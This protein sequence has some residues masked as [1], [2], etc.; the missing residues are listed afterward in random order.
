M[1]KEHVILLDSETDI[2]GQVADVGAIIVDRSGTVVN[3]FAVL[4]KGVYDDRINHTLFYSDQCG[5]LWNQSS[6]ERRYSQYDM[7]L[8]SGS[9]MLTSVPAINGWLM[10]AKAQYNPILTAYNLPFDV[11]HCQQTG[12]DLTPFTRRFCLWSASVSVFAKT[13]KYRQFIL[14]HHLFKPVTKLGNMSYP[15]N[16]ETMARFILGDISIPDEPHTSLEDCIGY[17]LPVLT[18][19]LRRKFLKWLLNEPVPY[20]WHWL[21]Q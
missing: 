14:D 4:V 1:R 12:I 10:R 16:C 8:K 11:S 2:T 6:L 20:S 15:T 9:R 5:E 13:K 7:M 18:K 17:E 19:L 3:Q 21:I